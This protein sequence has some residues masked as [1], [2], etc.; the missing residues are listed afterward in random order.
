M[1][2]RVVLVNPPL[3]KACEPPPGLLALAGHLRGRGIEVSLADANLGWQA[4]VLSAAALGEAAA[5]LTARGVTGAPVTSARRA[6]RLGP[7]AVD[8]LRRPE[9]YADPAAYR[10]AL[11]GLGEA[12]RAL[13][14]ARGVRLSPSDL[15][16]SGLSPLASRDLAAAARD[17]DALGLGAELEA[18]ARGLLAADPEVVGVST[19][20]LSQALPAFALA[21]LLRRL[22][23]GGPLVLG[24]GLVGSWAPRLAPDSALF[25]VWDALVAGPGEA[26]LEALARP[27]PAAP[28]PGLLAPGLG[29]WEPP[30]TG[31]RPP[32]CFAPD[33]AGLPWGRYLSPGPVL[34]LAAS[35]GCYWRRCAFCPE[36]AQDRQAFRG[37]PAGALVASILRARDELGARW[38]HLTD[39]AVPPRALR[40]LARGLRGQGIGW[41]GFSRLEPA[42]LDPGLADDL[43]E[44]GCAML[45]LGVETPSQRLLD[46]LGKGTRADRAG[47]IVGNL[48]RAGIRTFV[49]LL[50]GLPGETGE[51]A[52]ATAGWAAG[53]A[54]AI[55]FLNL[56]LFSHP[57]GSTLDDPAAEEPREEGSHDLSLY[58]VEGA[59]PR[60]DRRAGRAALAEAR[61]HPGLRAI[62]AR[63]PTGFTSN[64]AAFAPLGA[65]G[66]RWPR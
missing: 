60:R 49:Y 44:G 34:P 27:G 28:A 55:T 8:A 5:T 63:T 25:G 66:S 10:A 15:E 42:L 62:L 48:T 36:A 23:F 64:H 32:V 59:A 45:Q 33:P 43:A 47:P 56:A 2:R 19:T 51:E 24:G 61:A 41:Y 12:W 54:G 4:R 26:A 3:A 29:V 21:G 17:P 39:D 18:E 9:A 53:H 46:R 40:A 35:R 6:V 38:V 7:A 65:P 22:G 58:R 1:T 11:A 52:R 37:A 13:S 20:Y 57:R 30:R 16:H 31:A 50:F 14:R